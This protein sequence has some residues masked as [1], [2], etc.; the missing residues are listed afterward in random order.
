MLIEK[1]QLIENNY[2]VPTYYYPNARSAMKDLFQG[3]MSQSGISTVFL[4]AYIGISP[5]EG[6]GIY[7]PVQELNSLTVKFYQLTSKL[8]IDTA[9]VTKLI[10]EQGEPFIFLRVNYFG[11]VDPQAEQIYDLV[12]Q[13]GGWLIEDNAH[14]FFT[15]FRQDFHYS[16]A[17]FFSLHKQFPFPDGG[18]LC[19]YNREIKNNCLHGTTQPAPKRNPWAYDFASISAKRRKNYLTLQELS[20][21]FCEHWVPVKDLTDIRTVPQTFP[22][23]LTY[24]DRFQVYL[25]MNEKGYGVTSLYHTLIPQ[26][27]NMGFN[28]SEQISSCILNLPVHQD[29]S[30]DNYCVMLHELEVACKRHPAS[31]S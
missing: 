22:I 19:I 3:L 6:S 16:D 17:A 4:P 27:Y 2:L 11:F 12:K 15:H 13:S 31:E 21:T 9:H 29:V 10:K 26:L 8:E 18:M 14:S 25:E 28:H 23:F 1:Q 30:Y 20:S 24:S 5:K 7:D